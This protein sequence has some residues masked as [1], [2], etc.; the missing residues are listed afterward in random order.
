MKGRTH[1]ALGA[2]TGAAASLALTGQIGLLPV[3]LGVLGSWGPDLDH[4]KST[5]GRLL[6]FV[7]IP[8]SLKY[9]HRGPTHSLEWAL[10]A[11]LVGFAL[12]AAAA[13]GF[14]R[15]PLDWG[16][17]AGIALGGGYASHILG[18]ALS[19]T[20][21][22]PL[23]PSQAVPLWGGRRFG[24]RVF[25]YDGLFEFLVGTVV[26][27]VGLPAWGILVAVTL[28]RPHIA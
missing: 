26:G 22:V 7:S 10:Y 25:R 15:D 14:G 23:T 21:G 18:D 5:L 16:T 13:L 9:R 27:L 12:G 4:P 3:A 17:L 19:Y 6:P 11:V 24:L 2:L 1:A 8:L 20:E 28:L